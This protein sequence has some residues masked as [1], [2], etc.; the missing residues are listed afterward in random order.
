MMIDKNAEGGAGAQ[1]AI[2]LFIS[3]INTLADTKGR[4]IQDLF[5]MPSDF[6]TKVRNLKLKQ[7]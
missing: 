5:Q 3:H 7:N 4:P 2:I 1:Q 6:T